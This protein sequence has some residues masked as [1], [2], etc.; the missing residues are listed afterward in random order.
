M[1]KSASTRTKSRGR[2]RAFFRVGIRSARAGV[3]L[4]HIAV[5]KADKHHYRRARKQTERRAHRS[6]KR[7]KRCSGHDDE[8]QPTE[9]P[10]ASAQTASGERYAACEF[11]FCFSLLILFICDP[12][13]LSAISQTK[14]YRAFLYINFIIIHYWTKKQSLFYLLC[15]FRENYTTT[16]IFPPLENGGNIC[17][18]KG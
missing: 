13:E 14:R 5:V 12:S 11:P 10:K 7:Q 18:N 15:I 3:T 16:M 9:Q 1:S 17:Y 6:R 4:Q 8:P 2:S